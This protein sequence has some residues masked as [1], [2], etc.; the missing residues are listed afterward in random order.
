MAD[1][2]NMGALVAHM[3]GPAYCGDGGEHTKDCKGNIA[4]AIPAAMAVLS[5]A[6]PATGEGIC[7]AALGIC[8]APRPHGGEAAMAMPGELLTKPAT[9][10]T[11]N[12][13]YY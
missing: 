8:K 2:R 11:L 6:I 1:K 9:V 13:I 7:H 5:R 4:T 3:Q 12:N 10:Q